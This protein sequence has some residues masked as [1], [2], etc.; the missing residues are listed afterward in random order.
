M[1]GS[2]LSV[3][4]PCRERLVF[5]AIGSEALVEKALYAQRPNSTYLEKLEPA[6]CQETGAGPIF[7]L[8]RAAALNHSRDIKVT[9]LSRKIQE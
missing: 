6:W 5:Q 2:G 7:H 1:Q 4:A 8:V 3:A 9:L